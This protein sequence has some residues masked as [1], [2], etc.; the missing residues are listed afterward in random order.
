MSRISLKA[1][2]VGGLVALVAIQALSSGQVLF[3]Y[4]RGE[5]RTT[6]LVERSFTESQA[7]DQSIELLLQARRKEK[8]FLSRKDVKLLEA[9]DVTLEELNSSLGRIVELDNAPER[10]ASAQ[11]VQSLVTR[12]AES[13]DRIVELERRRG[14]SEKLGLR[15]ALRHAVHE[16]E[17]KLDE[18]QD[19]ELK[20][21]MLMCRR[22]E[23][24]YLLRGASKYLGRVDKRI[25][26]FE[27]LLTARDFGED[28]E[29]RLVQL[30]HEYRV[31]LR[32]LAGCDDEI[33]TAMQEMRD[34]AHAAESQL[35]EAGAATRASISA[36][37]SEILAGL[38]WGRLLTIAV[39]LVAIAL[40]LVVLGQV[41]SKVLQTIAACCRVRSWSSWK[42]IVT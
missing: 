1:R 17:S 18:Y 23:K 19:A 5:A 9:H 32:E 29:Q 24:D 11:E 21:L 40:G 8:D 3:S 20:V 16:V 28:A 37:S 6:K 7:T 42:A 4:L 27:E 39:A 15:G 12:Y 38:E 10:V 26:E 35:E 25:S 22:H 30:M 2:L 31:R 14:L 33:A 36:Q 13:F 34:A 41:R